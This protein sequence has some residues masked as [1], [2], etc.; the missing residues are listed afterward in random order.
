M[1]S[2]VEL[3]RQLKRQKLRRVRVDAR[4]LAIVKEAR[5]NVARLVRESGGDVATSK[6]K[7]EILYG[8]AGGVYERLSVEL[9]ALYKRMVA[10]EAMDWHKTAIQDVTAKAGDRSA[11]ITRFSPERIKTYWSIINPSNSENLSA[12]FTKQM[13][14]KDIGYLRKAFVQTW[15]QSQVEGWTA[16]EISSNLQDRWDKLAGNMDSNRF[17]DAGGRAWSN[18]QYLQM[19]TRTTQAR[20]GREAYADTLAQNGFDLAR[21]VPAGD[22][23]PKCR[24]WADLIVSV[25][26]G[27]DKY[28]SYEDAL[29]GGVFHPNCDCHLEYIDE[30]VDADAVAQQAATD[31]PPGW[32]DVEMVAEYRKQAVGE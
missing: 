30:D 18:A 27:N 2:R 23:C 5:K 22:S 21:I 20:V 19:L 12:V 8:R 28:P 16:R 29:T 17:V 3:A 1:P 9:D 15:R 24:A 6:A 7:R 10:D 25:S 31:N 26:G 14:Q 4:A 13:A 32:S 11:P